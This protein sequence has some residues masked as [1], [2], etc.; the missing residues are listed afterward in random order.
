MTFVRFAARVEINVAALSGLGAV[1]N[2]NQVAVAKVFYNGSAYEVPVLTGNALKH[3]H[4]VYAA[5]EYLQMGGKC[6]NAL[7][8]MG[9]GLRGYTYDSNWGQWKVASDECEAILDFCNDLHGFLI[10]EGGRSTKRDSLVKVSFATPVL[11]GKNLEATSKFAVQHNRV[12]AEKV[13]QEVGEQA[14]MLFKQEYASGLYGLY[15]RLDLDK[16]LQPM[17]DPC[18]VKHDG[19]N[20]NDVKKEAGLRKR[21]AVSALLKLLL[22]AGSKQARALPISDVKEVLV[23]A[24][25]A[26]LPNLVHP[27][28]PD[29][30]EKSLDVLNAYKSI[31]ESNV[32]VLYYGGGPCARGEVK[33]VG[34]LKE[35]F[36]ELLKVVDGGGSS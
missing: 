35:L 21:A 24:S 17:F 30:C 13:R 9:V 26:P 12:V 7:C 31:T 2:Y 22:G 18:E 23:A 29:Y 32:T 34:T 8:K 36:D 6:I 27:A 15:V 25:T 11:E 16:V 20:A 4:A 3:W 28:Y 14:M 33:R 5:E 1:G 19:C 10:A